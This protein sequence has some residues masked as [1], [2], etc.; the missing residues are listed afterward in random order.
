MGAVL[1]DASNRAAN[2]QEPSLLWHLQGE[3]AKLVARG[4]WDG[5]NVLNGATMVLAKGK[6]KGKGTAKGDSRAKGASSKSAGKGGDGFDGNCHHCGAN[7]HRKAQCRDLGV[8][9]AAKGKGNTGKVKGKGCT[10][11]EPM[12]RMR[13][14]TP[15]T[16][17]NKRSPSIRGKKQLTMGGGLVRLTL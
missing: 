2:A 15:R 17:K 12:K 8:E 9:L 4:D 10:M 3:C 11:L 14:R 16:I 6:G 5:V 1:Q 13:R 7:G